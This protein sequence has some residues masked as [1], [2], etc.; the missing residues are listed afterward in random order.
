MGK[1]CRNSDENKFRREI[2]M[3]TKKRKFCNLSN[4]E[5]HNILGIELQKPL[6]YWI[7]HVAFEVMLQEEA[8]NS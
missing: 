8:K 4:R 6:K 5:I 3:H 7:K 2:S 1:K